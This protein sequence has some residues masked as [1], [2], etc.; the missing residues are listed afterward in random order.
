ML[1]SALISLLVS[2]C[3]IG[4]IL[5][6]R[7]AGALSDV[8]NERSL[9]TK[10]TPRIG[11]IG[12][13]GGLL[14]GWL[15]SSV[16]PL[17]LLIPLLLLFAI[18]IADDKYNL[19]VHLRLGTHIIAASILVWGLDWHFTWGGVLVALVV[20]M[21]TVWMTNLYNFMDGA[22]GLAGGMTIFGFGSYGIA[23]L[24]ANQE[25]VAGL[26]F[27]VAASAF[28]FIV[29]NFHPAKIFMG[30]AGSIPL[31]FFA[32][33]MGVWGWAEAIW[34]VWLPVLVFSPFIIDA[35]A[36]LLRRFLRGA[37]V[38]EAHREHYYQR[39]IQM[40]MGHRNLA[41]AEYVLMALSGG[42]ALLFMDQ[43]SPWGL[44]VIWGLVYFII[45]RIIDVRWAK[46]FGAVPK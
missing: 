45:M 28:G 21:A 19:P 11:G 33:A 25:I 17:S 41:L 30:D 44:A 18:S 46:K 23:A 2:A 9:H 43:S 4:L 14:A 38:T 36:T 6:S 12:I 32:A 20:L 7:L 3:C 13:V 10:V 15:F 29:F 39:A 42:A 27:C 40:G 5:Q 26:N 31:G 35:S 16:P 37:K 34:P 24:I 1:Q 22:D 8:P